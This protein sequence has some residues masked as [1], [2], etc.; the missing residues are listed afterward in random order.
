MVESAWA[1]GVAGAV[2]GR[3]SRTGPST[4]Q[5][6]LA[7]VSR[8]TGSHQ[9]VFKQVRCDPIHFEMLTGLW[10]EDWRGE[11]GVGTG[12]MEVVGKVLSKLFLLCFNQYRWLP[13][14]HSFACDAL[15]SFTRSS[16]W[17]LN[18]PMALQ[19]PDV[20]YLARG[21]QWLRSNLQLGSHCP[22]PVRHSGPSPLQGAPCSY[23][24]P[25]PAP[26]PFP[27]HGVP[28]VPSR[29]PLPGTLSLV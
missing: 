16:K 29:R 26:L 25:S 11:L 14:R 15:R 7:F 24:R 3:A 23:P 17:P 20:V 9:E 18:G 12:R 1:V 19:F 10:R 27:E 13:H 4:V 8:R 6:T 21:W 2:R 28:V 5:R 22:W